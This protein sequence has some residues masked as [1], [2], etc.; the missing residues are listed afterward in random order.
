[1]ATLPFAK[2]HYCLQALSD[3]ATDGKG[4]VFTVWCR[5]SVNV[6]TLGRFNASQV[7]DI[8]VDGRV[9]CGRKEELRVHGSEV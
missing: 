3:E 8:H 5:F 6:A 4:R 2:M 7:D 1:M 9:D